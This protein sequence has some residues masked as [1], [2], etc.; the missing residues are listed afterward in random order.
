MRYFQCA[1][2][3]KQEVLTLRRTMIFAVPPNIGRSLN[4]NLIFLFFSMLFVAQPFLTFTLLVIV[5]LWLGAKS[6]ELIYAIAFFGACY[7]GLVNATKFPD[8]DYAKYLEWYASAQDFSLPAFLAIYSREPVYWVY[9]HTIANLPFTSEQ[10]FVFAST[11]V[12]YLIFI[13][14]VVRLSLGLSLNARVITALVVAL[15]FFAP[16]FSLSAHLM[17]Q[18]AAASLVILFFSEN[19]LFGRRYWW[20][21]IMAIL[22]HYSAII[23]LPFAMIKKI[24][25]F[26]SGINF[27]LYL[28]MLPIL[29][30]FS[31]GT[32]SIFA[33]IPVIGF[34]F[35]RVASEGVVELEHLSYVAIFFTIAT[36]ALS[37]SNLM[38]SRR[39]GSALASAHG[40]QI[41][42]TVIILGVIVLASN[43]LDGA[44][45]IA[46]R[47]FFYLYFFIGLL[48]PM[49][50]ALHRKQKMLIFPL[51]ALLV[52]YF[53]YNSQFGAWRYATIFE[54]I[55]LPSW[56]LWSYRV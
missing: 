50:V 8:G 52:P 33:D 47:F 9:L 27:Y 18:F 49:F 51:L 24:G 14:A 53:F 35:N 56:E 21:L 10:L 28:S 36:M 16:L 31:K 1:G 25:R 44:A 34:V 22:V 48:L 54:L 12:S 13:I 41:N 23:F 29:Y 2:S 17:R 38:A 6:P 40:W 45:E 55:S 15:M 20:I 5:S 32:A 4:F 7:L 3:I 30:V 42:V 26:S 19:L 46:T 39:V 11:V 37:I 43:M